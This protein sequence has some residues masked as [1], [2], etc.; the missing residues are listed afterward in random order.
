M[1]RRSD[2]RRGKWHDFFEDRR[3]LKRPTGGGPVVSSQKRSAVVVPQI[4]RGSNCYRVLLYGF[5]RNHYVRAYECDWARKAQPG[6]RN[7]TQRNVFE[8]TTCVRSDAHD[9]QQVRRTGARQVRRRANAQ[10]RGACGRAKHASTRVAQTR[11]ACRRAEHASTRGAQTRDA[12]KRAEHASTQGAQSRAAA[13]RPVRPFSSRSGTPKR[14]RVGAAVAA[15]PA[16][17][18]RGTGRSPRPQGLTPST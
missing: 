16:S 12:C 11:G 9:V 1:V 18:P 6:N 10:T 14:S 13:S 15:R 17:V 4:N 2:G 8:S 3:G 5:Y 7:R